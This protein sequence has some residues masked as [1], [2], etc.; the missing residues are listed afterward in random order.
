LLAGWLLAGCGCLLA[1]IKLIETLAGWMRHPRT[2][3]GRLV[4]APPPPP[5]RRAPG[6]T[7]RRGALE[8]ACLHNVM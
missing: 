7:C 2:W 8:C 1:A 3:P 5:A 6:A 4:A